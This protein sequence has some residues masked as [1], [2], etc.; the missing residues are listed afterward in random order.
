MLDTREKEPFRKYEPVGFRAAA[1][2][3]FFASVSPERRT[4]LTLLLGPV[5]DAL[6]GRFGPL[7]AGSPL[8]RN[9]PLMQRSGD[10]PP[11]HDDQG[12]VGRD[13]WPLQG[14]VRAPSIVLITMRFTLAI[15]LVVL[16]LLAGPASAQSYTVETYGVAEGLGGVTDL[17]FD[18]DEVLWL[19]SPRGLVRYDGAR[20]REIP[21]P[22]THGEPV[23]RVAPAT[24]GALWL[25]AGDAFYCRGADGR[26]DRV[27]APEALK[28]EL[29]NCSYGY[30][31][32]TA[33]GPGR[34]FVT[35]YRTGL[36]LYGAGRWRHVVVP[37]SDGP[38]IDVA[39]AADGT[40]WVLTRTRLGTL[41]MH[42][43]GTTDVTWRQAFT[44]AR[45]VRPHP[46]GA[47]VLT[48]RGLYRFHFDGRL[49]TVL[50]ERYRCWHTRPAVRPDGS[51]ALT[52]EQVSETGEAMTIYVMLIDAGGTV[53]HRLTTKNG[54]RTVGAVEAL[55]DHEGGLWLA[56]PVG[57][58]YLAP[59]PD[60]LTEVHLPTE[61]GIHRLAA[62][63]IRLWASTWNGLY[64][65]EAGHAPER[66]GPE[67]GTG[68][69]TVGAD[70]TVEWGAWYP[71]RADFGMR[72]REG[73]AEKVE[74]GRFLTARLPDGRM[75]YRDA[76]TFA[77]GRSDLWLG[78]LRVAASGL[79]TLMAAAPPN[80]RIWISNDDRL[81][82]I[83]DDDFG[84]RS[85]RTPH[86]VRAVLDRFDG[87]D[88][89]GLGTDR[90]GRVWV[91]TR[92]GLAVLYETA[93][94]EW[95][96]T[97]F[98]RA[99]G[100]LDPHVNRLDL[101]GGERLWLGTVQ[102]VQG[103]TL[104]AERPWLRPIP[105]PGLNDRLPNEAIE[106]VAETDDGVLWVAPYGPPRLFRYHW[107][108]APAYAA[109][110]LRL[111]EVTVNDRLL[112]GALPRLRADTSRIAFALSP[113]TYLRRSEL[114][115]E[116]RLVGL[117]TTWTTLEGDPK[118]QFAYLVPG[119]YTLEARARRD[120]GVPGPVLR[121][122]LTLAPPFYRA[123][124]FLALAF[125]AAALLLYGAYRYQV[126]RR[127]GIERLRLRIA[128]DLHDDLGTGLTQMS[129]MSEL[130]RRSA[131]SPVPEDAAAW[132][133]KIGA[134]TQ[135]LAE[136]MRDVVW[137]I[138]PDEE[139]WAAL[140]VR[141]RDAG[142]AL[143]DPAGIAFEMHGEVMGAPP[144]LPLDV[145]RHVILA[146]KEALNNAARHGAPSR[147]EVTYQ[148]SGV[149]LALRVCD[150]G[151][152]FDPSCVNGCDGGGNG[153]RNLR[154]RAQALGG[155]A[156][157]ESA[158]G[159]GTCVTFQVPL[160][161][162]WWLKWHRGVPSALAP[163]TLVTPSR[164]L[165]DVALHPAHLPERRDVEENYPD[166]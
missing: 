141:M 158:P 103:F 114:R 23:M 163:S 7:D 81:D 129:L 118:V 112:H 99:D 73:R 137:M 92:R 147:V 84:S 166:G 123:D 162:R 146:F 16:T 115:Y 30:L 54:L 3:R 133:Q 55:Y 93:A 124:W 83:Q 76:G 107:R 75:L 36:W 39:A 6:A 1:T 91:G 142:A 15:P 21:L 89:R 94:A 63:G 130:A 88:I 19:A 42:T 5:H 98:D 86:S 51:I 144:P 38:V 14:Y 151:T 139:A 154:R 122:A 74:S 34:L 72:Y 153:L 104:H 77:D 28:P 52:V 70:G 145:R 20:F 47:W 17:A 40:W 58:D 100:L 155:E 128:T 12:P 33:A 152:G 2:S 43:D 31:G 67:Q 96:V 80:G 8:A 143:L 48:G 119:K 13:I 10:E 62:D 136:R 140:E 131:L 102:G 159:K 65:I 120:E 32:L 22:G 121:Q 156:E 71:L 126:G 138:R 4:R 164:Y 85:E 56:S 49:E 27:L 113:R 108:E 87:L 9:L 132:A 66:I 90:W 79:G 109:P 125:L 82:T 105:L 59:I 116:Y 44:A 25:W 150:D 127:L 134:E 149:G 148:L 60:L 117:D 29:E 41:R 53:L 26:L 97:F 165:G 45:H 161:R 78:P 135:A 61:S 11:P 110:A 50:D 35:S 37:A 64:R 95:T 160:Q 24:D 157:V 101:A 18:A 111:T 69:V 68:I 46:D 106:V 57:L